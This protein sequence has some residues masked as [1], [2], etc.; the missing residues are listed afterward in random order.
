MSCRVL[1]LIAADVTADTVIVANAGARP[2][3][4]DYRQ[5]DTVDDDVVREIDGVDRKW[6]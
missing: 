5:R 2:H 6:S 1:T 3:N 4:F